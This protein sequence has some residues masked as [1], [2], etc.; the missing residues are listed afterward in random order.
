MRGD[1]GSGSVTKA[2]AN[3]DELRGSD[4]DDNM[5]P[6]QSRRKAQNRAA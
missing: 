2:E 5:T 1:G 4:D 6:A 3:A